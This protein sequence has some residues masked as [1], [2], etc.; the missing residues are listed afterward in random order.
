L[1]S[2]CILFIEIPEKFF[3]LI[4]CPVIE[5]LSAWFAKMF[6]NECIII[7]YNGLFIETYID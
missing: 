6:A 7:N 1:A 3:F 5:Y 4:E 2:I